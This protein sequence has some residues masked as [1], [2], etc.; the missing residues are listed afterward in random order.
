MQPTLKEVKR[1]NGETAYEITAKAARRH[2]GGK[3]YTDIWVKTNNPPCPKNCACRSRSR[4]K[5]PQRQSEH[6][7]ARPGQGR[8]RDRPQG[9]HSRRDGP[10]ASSA[11]AAPTSRYRFARRTREQDVHVLTVTLNPNEAGDLKRIIRVQTDLQTGN[12]IEF[13]AQAEVVP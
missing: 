11:S 4:S 13:N 3:W 6:R 9:H 2:A 10:S 5:R 8:H 7:V 12:E 1:P